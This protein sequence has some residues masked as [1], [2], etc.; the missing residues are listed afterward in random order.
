MSRISPQRAG[1]TLPEL[2]ASL[3][4][5]PW[6][7]LWLAFALGVVLGW[8]ARGAA[9]K[10]IEASC[11]PSERTYSKSDVGAV[12]LHHSARRKPQDENLLKNPV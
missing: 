12:H 11:T 6:W 2:P 10:S 1:T 8:F 4:F 9:T 7:W 5:F 3:S